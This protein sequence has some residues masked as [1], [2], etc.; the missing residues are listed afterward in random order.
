MMLRI[1]NV[2]FEHSVTAAPLEKWHQ[3]L[4]SAMT[5]MSKS[6]TNVKELT[7]Y[8]RQATGRKPETWAQV[9]ALIGAIIKSAERLSWEVSGQHYDDQGNIV[10]LDGTKWMDDRQ[11]VMQLTAMPPKMMRKQI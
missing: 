5:H 4:W 3:Q 11:T 10:Q 8:W 1:A 2:E 7:Q 9:R 6:C